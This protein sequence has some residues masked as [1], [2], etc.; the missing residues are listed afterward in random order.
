MATPSIP[1]ESR[2]ISLDDHIADLK[3]VLDH[4]TTT[5][6][7]TGMTSP[8][9]MKINKQ[10]EA[11]GVEYKKALDTQ[12]LNKS[13]S[14]RPSI[15]IIDN[16]KNIAIKAI[17][18]ARNILTSISEI[19]K[20]AAAEKELELELKATTQQIK[21]LKEIA[22]DVLVDANVLLK[23]LEGSG[24]SASAE[25]IIELKK[26]ISDL[27]AFDKISDKP[28]AENIEGLKEKRRGIQK[29]ITTKCA[30]TQKL[31]NI[32]KMGKPLPKT[33]QEF[34]PAIGAFSERYEEERKSGPSKDSL[35]G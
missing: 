26:K 30:S 20:Q 27:E 12:T 4:V 10:I 28:S 11:V 1:R 8:Q 35:A 24:K 32:I 13:S 9:R 31:I 17:D 14:F 22:D 6:K 23:E 2:P 18:V 7:N 29:E 3:G 19:T 15:T 5:A 21:M 25:A 16:A 34:D 33:I